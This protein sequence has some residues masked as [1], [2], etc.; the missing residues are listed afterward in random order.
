LPIAPIW[1]KNGNPETNFTY[2]GLKICKNGNPET[3]LKF[4]D[5]TN[6]A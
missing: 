4:A 3:N 2:V 5:F 6:L 1:L